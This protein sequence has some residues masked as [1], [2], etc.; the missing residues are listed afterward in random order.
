MLCNAAIALLDQYLTVGSDNS[1]HNETA[2]MEKHNGD[3]NAFL[4]AEDL[5]KENH[6]PCWYSCL[7][8]TIRL[9]RVFR[10]LCMTATPHR[11]SL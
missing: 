11:G 6:S 1:A 5:G 4:K 9:S 8:N 3:L 7:L 2:F 10:C